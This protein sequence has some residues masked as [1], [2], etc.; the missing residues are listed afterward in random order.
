M[1]YNLNENAATELHKALYDK[2]YRSEVLLGDKS[3]AI[4]V[5]QKN[6]RDLPMAMKASHIRENVFTE[7]EAKNLGLHVDEHT[8]YH[9]LGEKFFLEIIDGLDNI[10]EAYRGTKFAKKPERRENYFLLVSKLKGANGN[11]INVPVY[12]NEHAQINRVFID[13]NKIATNFAN[14]DFYDSIKSKFKK[15]SCKNKK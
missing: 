10:T 14:E 3:P 7:E 2:N 8:H 13:V 12:I 15:I 6:V 11:I 1:K 5:S 9:G 4:M